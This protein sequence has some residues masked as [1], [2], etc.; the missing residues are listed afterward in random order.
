MQQG[1]FKVRIVLRAFPIS[2]RN[3]QRTR[4]KTK[5]LR[6]LRVPGGSFSRLEADRTDFKKALTKSIRFIVIGGKWLYTDFTV[7]AKTHSV[8][9]HGKVY[10]IIV[11]VTI[12]RNNGSN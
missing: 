1:V 10:K 4:R 7:H 11:E 8:F 5:N 2:T 9:E 6:A 12:G 3:A